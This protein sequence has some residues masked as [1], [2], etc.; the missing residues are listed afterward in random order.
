MPPKSKR[1]EPPFE[2]VNKLFKRESKAAIPDLKVEQVKA[3][4][5][6][7][8]RLASVNLS[9]AEQLAPIAM[10]SQDPNV[11]AAM[12]GASREARACVE[13]RK[14]VTGGGLAG[15]TQ[16]VQGVTVRIEHSGEYVSDDF[17]DQQ[18]PSS[19]EPGISVQT[20]SSPAES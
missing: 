3:D 4:E 18:V 16:T 19:H 20:G 1:H 9:I 8:D 5:G 12:L 6:V 2:F 7:L 14:E 10:S 17:H 13:T 11:V 15:G